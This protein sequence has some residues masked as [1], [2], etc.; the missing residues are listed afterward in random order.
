M[1]FRHL[2]AKLPRRRSGSA[3]R[4]DDEVQLEY[5]RQQ[6]MGEGCSI[7]LTEGEA[8]PLDGPTE[9]GTELARP[10]PLPR[11]RSSSTS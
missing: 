10:Q 8:R 7:S 4:F 2:A 1:F 5:Y 6:K 11:S 3:Y 9:V